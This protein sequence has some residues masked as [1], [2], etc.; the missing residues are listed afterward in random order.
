MLV[1]RQKLDEE[2]FD[3]PRP[4][5]ILGLIALVLGGHPFLE[6]GGWIF[7]PDRRFRD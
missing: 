7:Q 6:V 1:D 5:S 4:K 2:G 3:Q